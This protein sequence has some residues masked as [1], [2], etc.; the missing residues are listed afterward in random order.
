MESLTAFLQRISIDGVIHLNTVS[1][2]LMTSLVALYGSHI[3]RALQ[4]KIRRY[5]LIIR[6][7][8]FV[9]ICAFGYGWLGTKLASLLE[10][11]L[12]R[13]PSTFLIPALLGLFVVLGLLAQRERQL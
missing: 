1:L 8:V 4:K 11:G 9:V 2:A 5:P 6:T 3:N 7:S 10:H 12:R 13:I